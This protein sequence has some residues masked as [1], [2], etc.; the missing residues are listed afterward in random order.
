MLPEDFARGASL[1]SVGKAAEEVEIRVIQPGGSVDDTVAPGE[2]GEVLI[3][4]PSVANQLW[5]Q[6]ALA[7]QIFD[8]RWWRSGDLGVIDEN[9]YLY[10]RGRID[11]MIISGGINVLPGE[12][13]EVILA[14]PLVS[15]C[16][17]IGLP[18]ERWGQRITAFI[19]KNG[20]VTPE[21]LATYVDSSRLAGYKKPLEYRFIDRIPVGNTG[22]KNRRL[23]R[24]KVAA[25]THPN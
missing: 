6:P 9:G 15:E 12:V 7:N 20:E 17:V 25:V 13:E 11:D 24:E 3:S 8:G 4:G 19:V 21:Q 18:D 10:L 2:E 1:E 14:H 5:E 22:K 23:L 16:A